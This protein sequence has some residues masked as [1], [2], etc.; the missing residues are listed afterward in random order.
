MKAHKS[1]D[2]YIFLPL[3]V[4]TSTSIQ[5]IKIYRELKMYKPKIHVKT[6]FS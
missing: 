3:Q 4:N 6:A 2:Q 1:Q 5:T